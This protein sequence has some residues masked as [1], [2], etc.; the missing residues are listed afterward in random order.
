M[1][2]DWDYHESGLE[3]VHPCS[4]PSYNLQVSTPVGSHLLSLPPVVL[5]CRHLIQ[6]L[7]VRFG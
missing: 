2:L 4:S 7:P 6:G 1:I 5:R 3:V